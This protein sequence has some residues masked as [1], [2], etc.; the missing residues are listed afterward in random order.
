MPL[1]TPKICIMMFH[2]SQKWT[3][4]WLVLPEPNLT[5]TLALAH[6]HAY[7]WEDNTLVQTL[8]QFTFKHVKQDLK[9][10]TGCVLLKLLSMWMSCGWKQDS[11]NKAC[12][13]SHV[14]PLLVVVTG[15]SILALCVCTRSQLLIC[16]RQ[17]CTQAMN[18]HTGTQN[19]H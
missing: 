2:I 12:A 8:L 7:T 1:I 18:T 10:N 19:R 6:T 16:P 17:T 9:K 3:D 5:H 13:C 11:W 4:V 14:S 15:L